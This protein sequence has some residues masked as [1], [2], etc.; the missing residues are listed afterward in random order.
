MKSKADVNEMLLKLSGSEYAE[1]GVQSGG[2]VSSLSKKA[3]TLVIAINNSDQLGA[4]FPLF[5]TNAADIVKGALILAEIHGA[6]QIAIHIPSALGISELPCDK[7]DLDI[8][9][10]FAKGGVNKRIYQDAIYHHVTAAISAA[11][12]A[13][14][15]YTDGIYASVNGAELKKYPP[16]TL[17]GDIIAESGIDNNDVTA[18]I[19]GYR[20]YNAGCLSSRLCDVY[21][22]NGSIRAISSSECPVNIVSD[23]LKASYMNGCGKCVFCREGLNQLHLLIKDISEGKGK[24][25]YV[26]IIKEIA[27]AMR[28]GTLCTLGQNCGDIAIDLADRFASEV[29]KHIRRKKCTFGVCFSNDICYI[30]PTLCSGCGKCISTCDED[31]IYGM[32]GYIHMIDSVDCTRCKKCVDSCPEEAIKITS[33]RPPRLP[34]RLTRV[35]RFKRYI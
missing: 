21:P 12:I 28:E 31:A 17:I 19:S 23:I 6:K 10:S 9:V 5:K 35:G 1:G 29:D 7:E 26:D 13:D 15:S 2:F 30:E 27:G 18:V 24:P 33:G 25:A 20:L 16:E 34:D 3:D 11:Q 14:Q 8:S 4:Y 32:D 22:E